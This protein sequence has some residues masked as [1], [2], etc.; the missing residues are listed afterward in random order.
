MK[1]S[2]LIAELQEVMG[3]EGDIQVTCTGTTLPDGHGQ[4]P[5]LPEVFE[6]TVETLLVRS[7]GQFGARRVRLYL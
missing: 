7:G 1:I 3:R 2:D 6:T 5:A 4:L